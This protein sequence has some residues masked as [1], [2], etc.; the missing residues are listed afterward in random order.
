MK[1]EMKQTAEDFI[2]QLIEKYDNP[3][4]DEEEAWWD[5]GNAD[6]AHEHG[7]DEGM[8]YII[9]KLKNFNTKEK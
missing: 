7:V 8:Q 5:F 1:N 3:S 4:F 6:D 9:D 2:K